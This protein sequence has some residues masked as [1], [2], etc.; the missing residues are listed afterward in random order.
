MG[1]REVEMGRAT[2]AA[3]G[4][5]KGVQGEAKVV[6]GMRAPNVFKSNSV[7]KMPKSE[8]SKPTRV[9]KLMLRR[10]HLMMRK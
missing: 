6:Q 5:A 9:A 4:E 3:K 10:S 2:A 7:K 8:S 1:S